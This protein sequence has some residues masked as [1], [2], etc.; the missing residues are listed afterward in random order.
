MAKKLISLDDAAA[1]GSRLPAAVR[2]EIAALPTS[3]AT[4]AAIT[5]AVNGLINGAPGALDTLDELAA[6]LGDNASFA[7]TVTNSIAGKQT[8]IPQQATAPSS[9]TTGALWLDTTNTPNELKRYNGSTWVAV[10]ATGSGTVADGSVTKAK[11]ATAV[12]TSVDKADTAVQPNTAP[13]FTGTRFNVGAPASG[14]VWAA[15]DSL[16]NGEWAPGANVELAYA[17]ITASSPIAT[18]MTDVPGL[19]ITAAPGARP[20]MI[21]VNLGG[22]YGDG[23]GTY[24]VDLVRVSDGVVIARGVFVTS[25]T[26]GYPA[27]PVL[28]RRIAASAPSDTYKVRAGRLNGTATGTIN[29][30]SAGA[31]TA[32]FV[33]AVSI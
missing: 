12:Q 29:P 7:T 16:G 21:E 30:S 13:T 8:S 4:T 6:A 33:Q 15:T 11:L 19:A 23:T 25:S 24:Q 10:G 3:A 20:M 5:T 18:T 2:A 14:K 32:A 1:A 27:P 22:V 31:V 28:K 9:P 17:E 26:A